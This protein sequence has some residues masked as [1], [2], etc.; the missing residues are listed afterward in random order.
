M[1]KVLS[2]TEIDAMFRAAQEGCTGQEKSRPRAMVES[3]DVRQSGQIGKE[4]LNSLK[5]INETFARNLSSAAA[6]RLHDQFE[7]AL[8]AIEQL[9]YRDVL[10]RSPEVSYYATFLL[11]PGEA[12]G[13]LQLD[14]GVAFPV[15][16]LLLGGAGTAAAAVREVT[17]IEEKLL[18]SMANVICQEL[19]V[20]LLP[21]ESEAQF[22]RRQPVAQMPRIMPPEE[23]TL[24]LTFDIGMAQARGVLNI[25]LP[26]A[27]SS[28]LMRS[29]RTEPLFQRTH[30]P[31]EHQGSIGQRLLNA[32][33]A[34][35]L[36]TPEIPVSVAQLLVLCPGAVLPLRRRIDEAGVVRIR[37]RACWSAQPVSSSN[38]RAAHLLEEIGPGE[39]EA[40]P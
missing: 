13:I 32:T 5:Q 29:L 17:E 15:V 26:S 10:S 40:V 22:E 35:E 1:E 30:G 8:V 14:L 18:E 16:D 9:T 24:T 28:A 3:W 4:Q 19:R 25:V 7:V 39:E 20:V 31:A 37:G 38:F 34:V 27:I 2:Q 33:V 36:D 21:L 6:G 12:R 11:P 23:R